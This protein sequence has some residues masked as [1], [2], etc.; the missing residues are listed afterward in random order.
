VQEAAYSLIP[1]ASREADHLRIGRLLT[2]RTPP[3]QLEEAIFEIGNQLNRGA[4]L[5]T[6]REEREQLAAFNLIAGKRA[7]A[8]T[9]YASALTYLIA[10]TTLLAEDCW[11]RRH[12]LIF[13]LELDRA[14]CELLTGALA[15]TEKRLAVLST[16]AANTVERARVACL[17][18]D[19]YVT[20][21]Q[22]RR[23]AAVG[24][25]YLRHLGVN[26][27]PHPTDEEA[28]EVYERIWSQLGS[29]TVEELVDLPLMI[30][31]TSLGTLDVLNGLASPAYHTD[32]N[33]LALITCQA[34]SFSI[35][36]GNC[37]GSCA[38]YT[39]LGRIAGA[40][41]GDYQAAYRFGR[42]GVELVE[43]RGLK[44]FQATTY[45]TFGHRVLPWTRHVRF[46]R[47]L[48][49]RGFEAAS[50]SGDFTGASYACDMI[51]TNFLT[52]GDPLVDVQR[53]AEHGV[54]FAQK[55]RFGLLV[56]IMATQLKLVRTL[57]GLTP[58]F[59]SFD[60]DGFDELGMEGRFSSN[61]NLAIAEYWYWI[62]KLQARFLAGDC[63]S[64]IGASSRA[65]RALQASAFTARYVGV[66]L[67]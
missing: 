11:E 51:I 57:R 5:I 43:R 1:Q 55:A 64:A 23:A 34:V 38:A 27:S 37:D 31:R 44:R 66:S 3:E 16:R 35:D 2:E 45:L 17:R 29:R 46:G 15:E 18:M 52:A 33:L 28:R 60:D 61:S 10:G 19:L 22:G 8:S 53:E 54:A 50:N 59:G 58:T 9:A 41:F 48:L 24:L 12:E 63:V 32:A 67:L 21:A 65:R 47:D 4:A 42:L 30:D 39:R 13:A 6:A 26:W 20:L 7:K 14:E 56:D 62:R 36:Q 40:R 49:R 25:E